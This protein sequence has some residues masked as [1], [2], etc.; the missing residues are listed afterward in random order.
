MDKFDEK[1][2]KV[3]PEKLAESIVLER[4]VKFDKTFKMVMDHVR[5]MMKISHHDLNRHI[6]ES[7]MSD[8]AEPSVL[9]KY[10]NELL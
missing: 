5:K 9:L 8:K 10:Y 7:I 6:Y 1:P 4:M 3:Q 2:Y